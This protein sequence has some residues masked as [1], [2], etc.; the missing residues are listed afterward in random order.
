[1]L[2]PE[3]EGPFPAV[4]LISGMGP[5]DRDSLMGGHKPFAVLADHLTKNGIAV[6]RFDKRG[7]GKSTGT[8]DLNITSKDLAGDV[9]AGVNFLKTQTTIDPKKIGLIGSS[10]GGMIAPMIATQCTD[11][12]FIALMAGVV[13]TNA[14]LTVKQATAQMRADGASEELLSHDHVLRTQIFD[15]IRLVENPK[16]AQLLCMDAVN[17]YIKNLPKELKEE[18]E[19]IHFAF[20]HNKAVVMVDMFN[21]PWYRFFLT[22]N[23]VEALKKI[24]VP[25]LALNGSLDH[26]IPC[27][28][29][30]SL[31]AKTLIKAGN[32]RVTTIE[33]RN[34]NHQF[35]TCKTGAI[36]EYTEIEETIAPQV[37]DILAQ[38]I[39]EQTT[40]AEVIKEEEVV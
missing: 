16:K 38:W 4:V 17:A 7:V 6:L 5:K 11:I 8:Y 31:I 24:T 27:R 9:I 30:L 33:M 39:K 19:N 18:S 1:M 23:P 26:I 35:Q 12:A 13:E 28:R 3:G 32:Q 36:S 29:S 34:M 20:T 21:S 15:I 10:E 40:K 37:L 14:R 25:L 2:E 22:Y